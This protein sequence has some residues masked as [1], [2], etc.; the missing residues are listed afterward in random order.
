MLRFAVLQVSLGSGNDGGACVSCARAELAA[1]ATR[2]DITVTVRARIRYVFIITSLWRVSEDALFGCGSTGLGLATLALCGD[3]LTRNYAA[4]PWHRSTH[5]DV[6][7]RPPTTKKTIIEVLRLCKRLA[8]RAK[9][10]RGAIRPSFFEA[11]R[12]PDIRRTWKFV[13]RRALRPNQI[14]FS[15]GL[16][17][18]CTV[19]TRVGLLGNTS[20][21][22][23]AIGAAA[24]DPDRP[25]VLHRMRR[26]RSPDR[27]HGR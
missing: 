15:H 9:T 5:F 25:T 13:V 27:D 3:R 26:S 20:R 7:D 16:L 12:R 21:A 11:Y 18:L 10:L 24:I 14:A 8:D 6:H 2:T 1:I 22:R 17:E 23:R 4:L 19:Q